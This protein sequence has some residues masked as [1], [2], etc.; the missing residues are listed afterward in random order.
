M[1]ELIVAV[2]GV[3]LGLVGAVGEAAVERIAQMGFLAHQVD[4]A[5][6]RATTADG[7]VRALADFDV[8]DGEDLA[9]LR[10]GVAHAVQVG[11]ALRVETA[12][13]RTIALRVAA[14]TGAKSDARHGAQ[15][16]LHVQRAGVFEHL[17]RNDSDRARRIDQRRGV[18]GRGG[19]FDLVGRRVLGFAGDGGGVQGN[20]VAGSFALGFFRREDHLP[21]RAGGDCD[22][23]CR[24]EQTW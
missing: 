17:L 20:G 5:A 10:T 24:G 9:A 15:R 6:G 1:T 11:V 16:V 21:S 4:A 8:F 23:D 18:L 7:G 12:D 14:F 22:T 2:E 3:A 13:E 19:F